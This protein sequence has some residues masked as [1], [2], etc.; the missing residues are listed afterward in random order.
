[1]TETTNSPAIQHVLALFDVPTIEEL[2]QLKWQGSTIRKTKAQR[3]ALCKALAELEQKQRSVLRDVFALTSADR[4]ELATTQQWLRLL[5]HLLYH[6]ENW[7]VA[8]RELPKQ[9][10]RQRKHTHT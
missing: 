10:H 2:E 8:Q 1:M 4:H 3:A 7:L 5:T 6:L 9:P